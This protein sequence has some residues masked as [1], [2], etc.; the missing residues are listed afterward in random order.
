MNEFF[1]GYSEPEIWDWTKLSAYIDCMQKG[2]LGYEEHLTPKEPSEA[3]A[4]GKGIHAMAE[5]WTAQSMAILTG[6]VFPE[7]AMANAQKA[8]LG[9]WDADLPLEL[10]EKLELEGDRRSYANACRLFE[11][12]TRKFPLEM[13]DKIV[14][15]ETPFTLYL[16]KTSTGREISWSGILDRAVQWQ[17]GIYYVDIKTSSY[18]INDRFFSQFNFS[19]QMIGYCWAG[20]ELS[21][22]NFSGIMIQGI[23]VKAPPKTAR[24]RTVDELIAVDIIPI[25]PE[26][27]EEW[28][29]M[30]LY[31]I[32]EIHAAREA[33]YFPMAMGHACNVFGNGCEFRRI[34]YAHPDQREL[35]KVENYDRKVWNPIKRERLE[36]VT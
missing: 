19:G 24:A 36:V 35:R 15:L 28:K 2:H 9:V 6:N 13:Y 32:D 4:F 7:T 23:E 21:L 18:P 5:V 22:G 33:G 30:I 8:F 12:Y 10:R 17:G 1:L 20:Q 34:C 11:A 27:I 25:L 29:Q 3:L 14:A 31:K 26:H 16:G